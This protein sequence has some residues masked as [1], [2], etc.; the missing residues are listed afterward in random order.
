VG[1]SAGVQETPT[2]VPKYSSRWPCLCNAWCVCPAP[3]KS[4]LRRRAAWALGQA[5][6]GYHDA[7]REFKRQLLT[8]TL[9]A[10]GGEVITRPGPELQVREF[11][12]LR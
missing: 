1:R 4:S 6:L 3:L 7:V 9:L 11:P 5:P 2:S 8:K 12:R 10:H